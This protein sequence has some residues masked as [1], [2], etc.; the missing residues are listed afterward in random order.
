MG[1]NMSQRLTTLTKKIFPYFSIR[2]LGK[3]F[4]GTRPVTL[5]TEETGSSTIIHPL[6]QFP[7][8][9]TNSRY[10]LTGM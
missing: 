8:P 6:Y 5:D 9:D 3:Q 4:A 7:S 2:K 10:R 1:K